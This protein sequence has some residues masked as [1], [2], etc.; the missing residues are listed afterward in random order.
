MGDLDYKRVARVAGGA[1]VP[2]LVLG[3][4]APF[5]IVA[6]DP[7]DDLHEMGTY[8]SPAVRRGPD[9]GRIHRDPRRRDVCVTR[10]KKGFRLVSCQAF[11]TP[12]LTPISLTLDSKACVD[13]KRAQTC[14]SRSVVLR[15]VLH[16]MTMAGK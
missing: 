6:G 14:F 15:R 3:M 12:K 13:F 5:G 9:E 1:Y 11:V 2:T 7:R 16:A 10:E 4:Y 8:S